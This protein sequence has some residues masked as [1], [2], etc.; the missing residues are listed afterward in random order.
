M[1]E[2]AAF[3]RTVTGLDMSEIALRFSHDRGIPNL[4][5]ADGTALPFQSS[6]FD[7]IIALD[8]FEHIEAHQLAFS[9]A[10]RVLRPGG[11]LVLSVPAFWWLWGPH[12]IALHHFRRYKRTELVSRLRSV[13]FE[14]SCGSY[15][16]F[17]LFPLVVLSRLVEKFRRGP[18]KASLPRVPNGL[19]VFL[20]RL[21]A[22]EGGWIRGGI[23]LP[24]G[25]SVVAVARKP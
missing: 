11:I 1:S 7:A 5:Q 17:L 16:V 12:D 13:G 9:E 25:S 15:A 24:W 14:I 18:A 4:I 20:V 10:L 3:S 22:L 2:A 6:S 23:R 8:I 21:L 19:N